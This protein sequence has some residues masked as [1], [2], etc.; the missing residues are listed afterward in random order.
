MRDPYKILGVKRTAS[1]DEIKAAWRALAKS[2]HPDRNQNDPLANARFAE[3]G[4]AYQLLKDPEKRYRYDMELKMAGGA[5]RAGQAQSP[6]GSFASF[7]AKADK[8]RKSGKAPDARTPDARAAG[9]NA[10][11]AKA[12]GAK[13]SGTKF[14]TEAGA[15]SG[16]GDSR[17]DH[18][19]DNQ[20]ELG[21]GD[22]IGNMWRKMSGK[23]NMPD[24]AP[25]LAIELKITIEDIMQQARPE[26]LLPDGRTLRVGLPEGVV[27]GKQ[28]RIANQG[29]R[30]P[31]MKRGDV[32]V[33]FRL[34]R[35]PVF[36]P[37]G[38]DLYTSVPVD[39][40]NAVLGCETIVDAPDGPVRITVPEWT[41]S[42]HIVRIKDRGL[43]GK[44]GIRGD[45]LAE[46]RVMLWDHPDDKV[47]DL[48]RS[49]REGLFL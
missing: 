10:S 27:D 1:T 40:E 9:A 20:H 3:A 16:A 7:F 37:D 33:T 6:A 21:A 26:I 43:P 32:I 42:D 13:D 44:D 30:I 19:H 49:L 28:V 36:R 46:I 29:H 22:I 11:G 38:L 15:R 45:L 41:S 31:G 12:S 5:A 8:T 35:H 24:K 17:Q 34:A 18:S 14:G 48:M 2:V 39:I 47:K 4:Q 23:I 25:D